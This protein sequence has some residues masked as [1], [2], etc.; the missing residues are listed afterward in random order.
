MNILGMGNLLKMKTT[1]AA[2]VEPVQYALPLGD[3]L[4]NL[5]QFIGKKITLEFTGVINCIATGEKIKKSYGQGYSYKSFISLAECDICIVKPELCHYSKGTCRQPEWGLAHCFQPHVVYLANT[6]NLK[7]GITRKVQVP[8]RWIDQGASEALPIVEVKDRHSAGL[9]E[10]ELA[11]EYSDKTDWRAMLKDARDRDSIDLHAIRERIFNQF[12]DLFDDYQARE[13]D[14]KEVIKIN[15][16]VLEYPKKVNALS[17]DKTASIQSRLMGIK[18]QYLI[19]EK[20][21]LNIRKHQGYQV[22]LAENT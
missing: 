9:V 20:G 4:I 16:P 5:N 6:G 15:Y 3:E 21:V 2:G 8:T 14:A 13:S 22:Q 12:G 10:I 7:I 19:F 11:K 1:L 17:L 18:G